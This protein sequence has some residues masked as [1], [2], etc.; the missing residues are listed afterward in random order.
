MA[1][2]TTTVIH[3]VGVVVVLM[4]EVVNKRPCNYCLNKFS[5]RHVCAMGDTL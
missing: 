2:G 4:L 5:F 3:N 1:G